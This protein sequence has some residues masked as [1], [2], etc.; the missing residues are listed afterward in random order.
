MKLW[1]WGLYNRT[2]ALTKRMRHQNTISSRWG[3][4][5]KV[6]WKPERRPSPAPWPWTPSLW[7][8]ERES[9]AVYAPSL[10]YVAMAA[11]A[12]YRSRHQKWEGPS[13]ICRIN[14]WTRKKTPDAGAL[15][16]KTAPKW[17]RPL[18]LMGC[19]SLHHYT[20]RDWT[21][22]RL[23]LWILAAYQCSH[24][25]RLHSWHGRVART[26]PLATFQP[27]HP[28][29]L[30]WVSQAH[31]GIYQQLCFVQKDSLM[32]QLGSNLVGTHD[33]RQKHFLRQPSHGISAWRKISQD[34]LKTIACLFV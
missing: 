15:S 1:G 23:V 31:Q 17:D 4:S 16:R 33:S 19:S 18:L 32:F 11:W 10:W 34:S 12:G 26:L 30:K 3:Q 25:R 13:L 21:L 5:K 6:V 20:S 22:F 8:Y 14:K 28:H 27:T 7:N 9:C 2:N 24:V 29:A